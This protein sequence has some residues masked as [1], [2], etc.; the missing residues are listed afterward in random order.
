[1]LRG[2][3]V[4]P[5]YLKSCELPVED[6]NSQYKRTRCLSACYD[7]ALD[8]E[9]KKE[10]VSWE[11]HIKWKSRYYYLHLTPDR[12]LSSLGDRVLSQRAIELDRKF[13]EV[14]ADNFFCREFRPVIENIQKIMQFE[15]R[16]ADCYA[17]DQLNAFHSMLEIFLVNND[18]LP[19]WQ[20]HGFCQHFIIL[21]EEYEGGLIEPLR[22]DAYIKGI[23]LVNTLDHT[24]WVDQ[25]DKIDFNF[26]NGDILSARPPICAQNIDSMS[27][28]LVWPSFEPLSA[29][30]FEGCSRYNIVPQGISLNRWVFHDGVLMDRRFFYYHDQ[31]HTGFLPDEIKDCP[32]KRQAILTTRNHLVKKITDDPV[33]IDTIKKI[34]FVNVHEYL[35]ASPGGLKRRDLLEYQDDYVAQTKWFFKGVKYFHDLSPLLT[36][37]HIHAACT[38]LNKIEP[39]L[40]KTQVP[41]LCRAPMF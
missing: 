34:G 27:M 40:P 36:T 28:R 25:K 3:G 24:L 20:V 8:A 17:R 9:L 23:E 41:D 11:S 26:N 37:R 14:G 30:F 7:Q 10:G 13:R 22:Q 39:F 12:F 4:L 31:Y 18:E 2:G 32:E 21:M 5:E 19:Y 33:V 15:M 1:M 6:E 38:V 35:K 29:D 16:Q